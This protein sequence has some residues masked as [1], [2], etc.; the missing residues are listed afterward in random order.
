[1]TVRNVTRDMEPYSCAARNTVGRGEST[2]I[3]I[4][5][6]NK[7]FKHIILLATLGTFCCSLLIL[8]LAYVC[9][10]KKL[11]LKKPRNTETENTYCSLRTSEISINVY[12]HLKPVIPMDTCMASYE[13]GANDYAN[14]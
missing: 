6:S 4:S 11:R 8:L 10:R 7:G 1:M 14:I 12:S 3:E 2:L 13:G 5:L 9:W